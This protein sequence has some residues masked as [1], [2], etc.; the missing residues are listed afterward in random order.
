V[1]ETDDPA[2]IGGAVEEMLRYLTITHGGRRRH[3][4]EDIEF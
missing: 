4:L 1:R 2:V 3:A